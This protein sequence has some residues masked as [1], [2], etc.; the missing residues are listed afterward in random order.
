MAF[1]T[2]RLGISLTAEP[3]DFLRAEPDDAD[4][5]AGRARR[6]DP[7]RGRRRDRDSG[8]VVDRAGAEIPAIEVSADQYDS[9]IG[10]AAGHFGDDVARFA[11]AGL[12]RGEHQ[13]ERDGLPA[14]H[15]PLEIFGIGNR[16]EEHTSE[17]QSLMR[18]SY[19]VF[20]LN[21]KKHTT[22]KQTS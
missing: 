12:A 7:F 1:V 13:L 11:A 17:L 9:G 10:I 4:R 2:V 21:K 5:A 18:I 14:L 22:K 15:H 8:G 6:H 3:A 20:C 16:S 19:A